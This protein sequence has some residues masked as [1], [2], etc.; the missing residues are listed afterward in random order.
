MINPAPSD[1]P[2]TPDRA[3]RHDR[4]VHLG[5]ILDDGLNVVAMPW[6]NDTNRLDL[7]QAG[8]AGIHR[9]GQRV[10][11][12]FSRK[13]PGQVIDDSRLFVIHKLSS[14]VLEE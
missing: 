14:F 9:H 11:A 7:V 10:T 2:E 5:A 3:P 6:K 1:S 13:K 4:N 12:Q 8:V